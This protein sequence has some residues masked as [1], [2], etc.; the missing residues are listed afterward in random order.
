MVLVLMVLLSVQR[1]LIQSESGADKLDPYY[2]ICSLR[3]EYIFF[4]N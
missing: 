3:L 1:I 2:N 4:F